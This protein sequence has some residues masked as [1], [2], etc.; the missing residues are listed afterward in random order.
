MVA[1]VFAGDIAVLEIQGIGSLF[2]CGPG[3]AGLLDLS[4]RVAAWRQARESVRSVFAGRGGI[5]GAP[6]F[7]EL[8]G[9]AFHSGLTIE[10]TVTVEVVKLHAGYGV[11]CRLIVGEVETLGI[12]VFQINGVRPLFG[13]CFRPSGQQ[14][15]ADGVAP[16]FELLKAVRSIVF[17]QDA[18]LAVV[19][20][21]KLNCPAGQGLATVHLAVAVLI[22]ISRAR[23]VQRRL[24]EGEVAG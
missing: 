12:A 23:D 8:D 6:I 9:P 3:P 4:H 13:C 24:A 21:D 14:G 17:G 15:F 10:D 11:E 7:R 16:G 19:G 2:G 20:L 1:E 5:D 22:F 18:D